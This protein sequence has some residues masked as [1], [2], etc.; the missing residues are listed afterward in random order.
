MF[1]VKE[2]ANITN[3]AYVLQARTIGPNNAAQSS[4]IATQF[5][6][7]ATRLFDKFASL[8]A[9]LFNDRN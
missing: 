6:V 3:T 2:Y 9:S 7:K 4:P 5:L 8:H 1:L